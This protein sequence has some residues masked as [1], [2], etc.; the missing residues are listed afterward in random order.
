MDE[1]DFLSSR[2]LRPF[3]SADFGRMEALATRLRALGLALFGPTTA[4]LERQLL[5]RY[6]HIPAGFEL[7]DFRKLLETLERFPSLD[8]PRYACLAQSSTFAALRAT[9]L[10]GDRRLML[11]EARI[12]V[13]RRA[14]EHLEK[15]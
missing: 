10:V 8:D 11:I 9:I 13:V 6:P 2:N 7:S 14:I 1:D 12:E 4:D 5:A 15:R 3:G